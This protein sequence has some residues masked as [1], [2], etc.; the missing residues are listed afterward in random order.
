GYACLA[1]DVTERIAAE[2][3]LKAREAHLSSIL[4]TVPDAMIVIDEQA[5]IQS[6]SR[7]AERLFGYEPTHVVGENI[8][9]LMPSPYREQHD[10]YLRRYLT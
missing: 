3:A 1:R 9:M 4:A 7:A 6:F 8:N 10:D 5:R 2:E